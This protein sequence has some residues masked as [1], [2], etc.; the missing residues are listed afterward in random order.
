VPIT[1]V[2]IG[3]DGWDGLAKRARSTLKNADVVIGGPR[4]LELLSDA[5]S[6]T[7]TPLPTPLLPGIGELISS[8]ADRKV[9][10]LASGDPMFFGIGTTLVRIFGTSD[11]RMLPGPS[12]ISLAAARLGWPLDDVEVVSLVGRPLSTLQPAILPGRRVLVLVGGRDGG[13]EVRDLL[14]ARGFGSSTVT[15]LEQLGGPDE[16]IRLEPGEHHNLAVVA[17][18]CV[19]DPEVMPL[20]RIVGLPDDAFEH[21]G[22]ITKRELRALALAVLAPVPGE[23]LWD[24]GAG[25]G[26]IGI[27]WMRSHPACRAIALEPRADRVERIKRNS[28]ALGVPG[29][30]V[31]N[32]P[33]PAAFEGLPTPDAIFLGGAVSFPG[34]IEGCL[35]ALRP[36]G[37]IV[38]NGVTVETEV[39]L[40]GWHAELGGTLTRIAVQRAEPVG[41][42]T[43]WRPALPVTQWYYR[44]GST[45]A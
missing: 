28:E 25:S 1:V 10:V 43:G 37:R 30:R 32:E 8:L 14:A 42:F 9:A 6:G 15:V 22:Q 36:G 31:I 17:I 27:E 13:D 7:R 34:V 45:S 44:A 21:D 40:A 29:L 18:D 33:A 2:G 5:V 12:S 11:L 35:G 39:V 19:A 4:Q 20:P 26:S 41:G 3:A 23:L 38:A 16:L 24:V